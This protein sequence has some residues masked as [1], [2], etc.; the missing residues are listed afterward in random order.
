MQTADCIWCLD[1]LILF[2][3]LSYCFR[4]S[5]INITDI[6]IVL[7]WSS[8]F[9]MF[10][11]LRRVVIPL[12]RISMR[13]NDFRIIYANAPIDLWFSTLFFLLIFYNL[14]MNENW[15]HFNIYN[16]MRWEFTRTILFYSSFFIL[17]CD[18]TRQLKLNFK[19]SEWVLMKFHLIS[20]QSQIFLFFYSS[21]S[22]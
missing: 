21:S 16:V 3:L 12:S 2:V 20:S 1:F 19:L 13:L 17:W 10:S 11:L 18:K 9:Q 5:Y 4:Y 7:T 14:K 8:F 15:G 22:H 6:K